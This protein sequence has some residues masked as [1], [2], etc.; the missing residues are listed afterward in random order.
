MCVLVITTCVIDVKCAMH[1]FLPQF[2][3]EEN[4]LSVGDDDAAQRLHDV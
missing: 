3:S 4:K 2:Y 1:S